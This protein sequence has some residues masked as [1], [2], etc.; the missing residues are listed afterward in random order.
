MGSTEGG[1]ER[2]PSHGLNFRSQGSPRWRKPKYQLSCKQRNR[3]AWKERLRRS[4][5]CF[6]VASLGFFPFV[7]QIKQLHSRCPCKRDRQTF[8]RNLTF[9]PII[10][11]LIGS[12]CEYATA[13]LP[14]ILLRY[15]NL[16]RDHKIIPVEH[17]T[18]HPLHPRY[19]PREYPDT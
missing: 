7:S 5:T 9:F 10:S 15:A 19:S 2:I 11:H 17:H 8:R 1:G 12:C 18:F 14:S 4:R 3:V 16:G 6:S 13:D